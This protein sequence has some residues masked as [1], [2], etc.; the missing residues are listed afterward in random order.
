MID[1]SGCA[2]EELED[3]SWLWVLFFFFVKGSDNRLWE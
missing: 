1:G 2:R 3:G